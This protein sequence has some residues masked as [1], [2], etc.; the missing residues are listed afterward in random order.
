MSKRIAVFSACVFASLFVSLVAAPAVAQGTTRVTIKNPDPAKWAGR[1]PFFSKSTGEFTCR[2]L[3]CSDAAK[4]TASISTSPTRS[5]D[6]QALAKLAAKIP[7]SVAQANANNASGMT[8]GRKVERVSS[9]ATTLRGY[10]AIVQELRVVGGE[11]GPVYLVKASM[12]VKSALV[13]VSSFSPSLELARRNRD[14][15]IKAMEVD[16][17]PTS[18]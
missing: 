7:D 18:R 5:P 15:F 4:V 10:P 6:P 16:D 11:K 9:G 3:A 2:P 8:P 13:N 12:F 17:T 1:T 14:L